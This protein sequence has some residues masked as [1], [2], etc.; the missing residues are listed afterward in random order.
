MPAYIVI[1]EE[2]RPPEKFNIGYLT[3]DLIRKLDEECKPW[4]YEIAD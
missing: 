2:G 3:V 1:R 4:V